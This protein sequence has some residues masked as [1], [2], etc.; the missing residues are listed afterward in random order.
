MVL[1]NV[2]SPTGGQHAVYHS[3]VEVLGAEYVFGGGDTSYSGVTLQRPRVPPPGSGWV[4]YQ[5]VE[6]APLT[7]SREEVN[8]IISELRSEF[9]ARSYDLTARNCNTFADAFCRRLCG[10]GI[11]GWVNR[12]AG[13]GTAVRSLVG[14]PPPAAAN[15]GKADIGAGGLAAA[16]LVAQSAGADGS[17]AGQ[18]EW[19]GVGVL[20]AAQ[21]D[22]SAALRAG[23]PVASE[24]GGSPELLFLLPFVSPVK[25]QSLVFEAPS[26]MQAATHVRVFANRRDLDMDDAAGGVPATQQG[27]LSWS[28]AQA[29]GFVSAVMEVNFLKFQ[30]L[31]NLAIY[32]S[33]GEPADE[34]GTPIAVQGLRLLGKV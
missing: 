24:D 23:T 29:K 18:V 4:F 31:G 11:P 26:A 25:L 7:V 22:A 1:L 19:G 12:L 15:A 33:R 10:Q 21:D 13:V 17:L 27:E 16:G 20:N 9:P 2:Y 14:S 5:S 34:D 8:R 32:L 6:I 30:N 3:G 28:Q